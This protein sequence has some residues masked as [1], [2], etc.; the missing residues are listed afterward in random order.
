MKQIATASVSQHAC[1][2]LV[3]VFEI[4]G[5]AQIQLHTCACTALST[6]V[7]KHVTRYV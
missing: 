1:T 6:C 3:A 5:T 7:Y 2:V 4:Y